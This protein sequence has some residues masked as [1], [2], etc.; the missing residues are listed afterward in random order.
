VLQD[1]PGCLIPWPTCRHSCALCDD[2]EALD[3]ADTDW[4]VRFSSLYCPSFPPATDEDTSAVAAAIVGVR[5]EQ[6]VWGRGTPRRQGVAHPYPG[7]V[8]AQV[9][10]GMGLKLTFI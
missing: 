7:G 3:P 8:E 1:G 9:S 6:L 2:L 5:D 10:L 4:D